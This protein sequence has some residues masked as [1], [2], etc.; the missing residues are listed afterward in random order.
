MRMMMMED[1]T[2]VCMSPLDHHYHR[3]CDVVEVILLSLCGVLPSY[4]R[5]LNNSTE[6]FLEY[7]IL[8]G[9]LYSFGNVVFLNS[10]VFS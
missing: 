9:V 3:C 8:E 5:P 7:Y 6:F 4:N 2:N 10:T 1:F